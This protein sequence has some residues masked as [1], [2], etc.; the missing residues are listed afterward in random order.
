MNKLIALG[1]GSLVISASAVADSAPENLLIMDDDEDIIY[2][3]DTK[4]RR[5]GAPAPIRTRFFTGIERGEN[6][7][8]NQAKT[9][10]TRFVIADGSTR[11]HPNLRMRYV[12]AESYLESDYPQTK[13]GG[14]LNYTLAPR[15]EAW[16]NPNFSYFFEPVWLRR[17]EAD[18]SEN[19]DI[20][21]KPGAQFT[22]GKHFVNTKA[23]YEISKR[24]RY[25][26]DGR[27]R[28][29]R[30]DGYSADVNYTYRYSPSL[31]FGL[32]SGYSGTFDNSDY[33]TRRRNYNI[34]SSVRVKHWYDITTALNVRY[35]RNESGRYWVG[36]DIWGVNLNNNIPYNRHVRFVANLGYAK[37]SRHTA[38]P[39][40]IF[41]D[42]EEMSARV[43]VNLAF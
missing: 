23:E 24:E 18:G 34:K 28:T 42:K 19:R 3:V 43:G 17:V 5:P 40:G 27:F 31:N 1:L 30:S 26:D 9:N 41:R 36:D 6:V 11:L 38:A 29:I 13:S 12:L 32:E 35:V 21:F 33:D 10:S 20:K 7:F 4:Q 25:N 15:Y 8:T 2:Q 37:S 22:F 39:N 16:V 14:R